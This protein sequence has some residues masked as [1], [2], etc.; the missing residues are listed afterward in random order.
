MNLARS[1]RATQSPAIHLHSRELGSRP[2]LP[3]VELLHSSSYTTVARQSG[4]EHVQLLRCSSYTTEARQGAAQS[5]QLLAEQLEMGTYS[6]SWGHTQY[7]D[8]EM[9]TYPRHGSGDGRT[10]D[11]QLEMGT[12]P[13]Y[14]AGGG[15]IPRI[16][17][18]RWGHT[19]YTQLEM[20][21][22]PIYADGDGDIPITT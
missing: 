21:T 2:E 17:S 19:Q 20:G 4:A 14:G 5:R 6:W 8:L 7:M 18:W 10:Q 3:Q 15:D 22:Y 13:S 16:R 11:T 12:Y 9:G 1:L